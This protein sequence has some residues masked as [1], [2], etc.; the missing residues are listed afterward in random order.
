MG[1][2]SKK[3]DKK[4]IEEEVLEPSSAET[5]VVEPVTLPKPR[6]KREHLFGT[7][8]LGALIV[9]VCFGLFGV[10]FGAFTLWQKQSMQDEA[11]SISGLSTTSEEKEAAPSE[12]KETVAETPKEVT[13]ENTDSLKA[14]QALDVIVMN[15]GGAKGVATQAA[16]FLKT[17][18]FTKVTVGNTTGNFTGTVVYSKNTLTKEAEAI[19]AKLIAKYPSIVLKEAVASNPETQT[20]SLTVIFGKE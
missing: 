9:V 8:L 2:F 18:G 4:E 15:G 17:E 14:A 7:L 1:I 5:S 19:K 10:G 16:T 11:P 3:T 13:P 6:G 12:T 20:A